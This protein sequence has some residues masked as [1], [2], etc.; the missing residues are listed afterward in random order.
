MNYYS[1]HL[2]CAFSNWGGDYSCRHMVTIEMVTKG[3]RGWDPHS[4]DWINLITEKEFFDE[5]D[6]VFY[7]SR[8][9]D[10]DD[11]DDYDLKRMATK[12]GP[13]LK[14]EVLQWLEENIKDRTGEDNDKGWC[15]GDDRLNERVLVSFSIFFHRKSDAF[16]FIKKWSIHKKPLTYFDYFKDVKQELNIKTNKLEEVE[17]WSE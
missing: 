9:P 15:I 3:K 5:K 7:K 12:T 14:K 1:N 13:A 2:G 11:Y 17:Q 6:Y 4:Q 8:S 16:A 10:Y